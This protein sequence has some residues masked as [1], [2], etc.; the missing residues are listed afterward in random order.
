MQRIGPLRKTRKRVFADKP[1]LPRRI[2]AR[3]QIDLPRAVQFPGKPERLR[4]ARGRH[5]PRIV[6]H[7]P[8]YRARIIERLPH[9]AQGVADI[10]GATQG[11]QALLA[12]HIV[13]GPIAEHL[14]QRR[15]EILRIGRGAVVDEDTVAVVGVAG[16]GMG[17]QAIER[18]VAAAAGPI[19]E[20]VAR[21]IVAPADHLVGIIVTQVGDGCA[22][23]PD[24]GAVPGQVVAVGVG[25]AGGLRR[26][27]QA[28][29]AIVGVSDGV[30][31]LSGSQRGR[32]LDGVM[33][34]LCLFYSL[35]TLWY[36]IPLAAPSMLI[37]NAVPSGVN[38]I[39]Y[40]LTRTNCTPDRSRTRPPPRG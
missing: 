14:A 39:S 10:P 21:R 34:L 25:R 40:P 4:G 33:P 9:A 2:P 24:F 37:K 13:G 19:A 30:A 35:R 12:V 3:P 16:A 11:A 15:G 6:L 18:V 7:T 26:P 23:L 31:N 38:W 5:T 29:Q 20:Q 1:P 36:K 32:G 17:D 22:V 27:G 28:L 8:H